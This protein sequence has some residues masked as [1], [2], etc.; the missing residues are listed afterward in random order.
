ME[1]LRKHCEGNA[2]HSRARME[3][4]MGKIS[5]GLKEV[6]TMVEDLRSEKALPTIII[7]NG[8]KKNFIQRT[9]A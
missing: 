6:N 1:R 9:I 3:E 5:E 2:V 7:F 4:I 8:E